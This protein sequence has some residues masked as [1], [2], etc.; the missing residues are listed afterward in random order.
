[1]AMG[2]KG[3]EER[4]FGRWCRQDLAIDLI[5][6]WYLASVPRQKSLE[7]G[8][9]KHYSV[10]HDEFEVPVGELEGGV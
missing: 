9:G 8:G 5:R 6:G 7:G 4:D 3:A 1:M 2:R 10:G